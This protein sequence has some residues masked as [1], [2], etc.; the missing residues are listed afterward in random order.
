MLPKVSS[1]FYIVMLYA[2]VV[3][4]KKKKNTQLSEIGL[5]TASFTKYQWYLFPVIYLR[6]AI[7][8]ID[9]L[10]YISSYDVL[11]IERLKLQDDK[12]KPFK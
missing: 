10:C 12:A 8:R 6:Y 1:S 4:Y 5:P 3:L 11:I 9:T 7:I 2:F